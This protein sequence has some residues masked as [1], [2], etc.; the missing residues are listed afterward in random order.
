M[1]IS[2]NDHFTMCSIEIIKL[3]TLIIYSVDVNDN[4][5]V[6]LHF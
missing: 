2:Q 4:K 5:T 6:L 1:L 3:Y